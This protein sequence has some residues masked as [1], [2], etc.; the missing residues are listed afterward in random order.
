VGAAHAGT[1]GA[2]T[3]PRRGDVGAPA[4]RAVSAR[5]ALLTRR[6]AGLDCGQEDS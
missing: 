5:P 1:R 4:A 3:H 2:G 6:G